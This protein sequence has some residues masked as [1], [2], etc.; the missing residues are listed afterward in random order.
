MVP[1]RTGALSRGFAFALLLLA[2]AVP[3]SAQSQTGNLFGTVLDQQGGALPG[4]TVTL[5][6]PGATQTFVTDAG[7]R[8]RFLS[9]SPGFYTVRAELEGLGSATRERVEVNI[10]RNTTLDVRLQAAVAEEITVTAEAPLIDVRKTGTGA[11]VT[12]IE[13]ETVPTARDPWVILQQVPGVLMDRINVGGNESGQQSNFVSKGSTGDQATFNVDGVNITDMSAT[14]SSPVYFDFGSFDELQVSTGGTDPRI[15]TPGAQINIVSKRGTNRFSGSGRYLLADGSWQADAEIPAEAAGYLGAIN[16]IDQNNEWGFEVGGPIIRDR[17]WLWGAYADQQIDLLVAQPVG[18]TVRF[19]DKTSLE[20][21]TYKLNAQPLDNNS[22]A[23][24]WNTNDKS[25]FGRNAAPNRPPETTWNQSGFGPDGN[26]KLEDTQIFNKNFYATV[27][28]SKVNGGFQ[29]IPDSGAKCVTADCGI[30]EA[31]GPAYLDPSAVWHRTFQG[32]TQVRPQDQWRLD[33]A[34]F[35]DLGSMTHEVRIGAGTREAGDETQYFWPH[36]Q[37][38]VDYGDGTGGVYLFRGSVA[39]YTMEYDDLYIGDTILF[40]RLTIQAGLRYDRQSTSSGKVTIAAHPLVPDILPAGSFDG[41]QAGEMEWTTLSPR[42]GL[43]FAAGED[44]RTLI[45]A[46]YNRYAGQ[47]GANSAGAG[48]NVGNFTYQY[49]YYYFEDRNADKSAQRDE[50][51]FD[52][53][54]V[55]FYGVDPENPG[56]ATQLFRY[57]DDASAPTTDELILGFEREIMPVFSVGFTYTHRE[58]NDFVWLRPEKT[59][60]AGDFYTADDFELKGELTGTLPDGTSVTR[61]WYDLK[62]G[63][64]RFTFFALENRPG[65]SQ[66]Y[67]GVELTAVKRMAN[68]WML[69]ANVSWNDWRQQMDEDGFFDPNRSL[70]AYG[71]STC[72]DS[73]VVQGSGTTSG[74]KAWIYLNSPWSYAI[75]GVYQV[76]V[77][78]VDLGFNLSGRAGYP[79]PYVHETPVL[80]ATGG[81]DLILMSDD[82]DEI[83][84]D[85]IHT[86]DLRLAKDLSLH[87]VGLTLSVDAF[88]VTNEQTVMQRNLSLYRANNPRPA[89][90]RITE[91]VSPAIFRLG[92]KITF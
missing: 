52:A 25:K 28:Y 63:I 84:H 31:T 55:G 7:G 59:R 47:L 87:G 54:L 85:D 74:S 35:F 16:E 34:T 60:G 39:P 5:S 22:F 58:M 36:D 14:G 27:M 68:R 42:I 15:M 65:Y 56:A 12:E 18:Q 61:P 10:G 46:A 76:P 20:T 2:L 90:N 21:Q 11:T 29:L 73:I 86:I 8:F 40:D 57:T 70:T 26:W 3:G 37:Y 72:D 89:A 33:T 30:N 80:Q 88:N 79:I 43:T 50:I 75:T 32:V 77:V 4:V 66:T 1:H 9:L 38:V 69:R 53:G 41:T 51:L 64:R 23:S 48:F 13:L 19:S 17:L 91:L 92:A 78:D 81:R 24:M 6:G 44:R 49:L 83:R 62:E 67:D 82:V 45:R 71:C